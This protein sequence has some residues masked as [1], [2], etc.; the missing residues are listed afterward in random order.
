MK[1]KTISDAVKK[2]EEDFRGLYENWNDVCKIQKYYFVINDRY[3][4]LPPPIIQKVEE[5][6]NDETYADIEIQTFTA[7]DLETIFGQLSEDDI[8]M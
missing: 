3:Q 1:D 6:N 5:L 2:L 4:G 7:K 8:L